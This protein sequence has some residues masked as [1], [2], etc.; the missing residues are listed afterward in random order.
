M[1]QREIIASS[2]DLRKLTK[3]C[4][5]M[6]CQ[7]PASVEALIFEVD[8]ETKRRRELASL[9]LCREHYRAE[10]KGLMDKLNRESGE[11]KVSRAEVF[12]IGYVTW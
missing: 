3:T 7:K 11:G 12:D 8:M 10:L 1:D 2:F 4:N 5:F 6:G 9:Y